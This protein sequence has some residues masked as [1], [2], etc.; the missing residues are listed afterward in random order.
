MPGPARREPTR[1]RLGVTPQA[2]GL[3]ITADAGGS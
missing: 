1:A 2:K 3:L